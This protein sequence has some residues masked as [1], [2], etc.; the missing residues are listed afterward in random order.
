M[1]KDDFAKY[2]R[3]LRKLNKDIPLAIFIDQLS[4]NKCREI[5]TLYQD[6]DIEQI[7]N[8]GYSPDF[9]PIEAV[10][11]KVKDVYNRNRVNYLVN[12][13]PY[14]AENIIR[15]AFKSISKEHCINCVYRS[16]KIL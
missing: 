6:L 11:S 16:L 10:F 7:L 15:D 9:N 5:K 14:S 13:T 1:N 2:L 3:K 4:V 12:K 8:V